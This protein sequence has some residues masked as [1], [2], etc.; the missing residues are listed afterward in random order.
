MIC[1]LERGVV[2]LVNLFDVEQRKGVGID[3]G[4]S[5]LYENGR[6]FDYDFVLGVK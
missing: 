4:S 1:I 5:E 2:F 6:N 3:G